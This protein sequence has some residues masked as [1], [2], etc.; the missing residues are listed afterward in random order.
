[1]KC[2]LPRSWETLPQ[3][4]KK[5]ITDLMQKTVDDTINE[6]EDLIQKVWLQWACIV[7]HEAFGFG[8]DRCMMFLGNWKKMYRKNRKFKDD[9][10]Q[11][12]Y[13]DGKIKEIFKDEY[14]QDFVNSL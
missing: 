4:E 10:E 6:E 2:N 7:L 3:R 12:A 11:Q 13:L 9:K 5:I 14:P 1:M 8:R